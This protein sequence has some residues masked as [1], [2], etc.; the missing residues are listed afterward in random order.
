MFQANSEKIMGLLRPA[1]PVLDVGG[2][3]HPLNRPNYIMGCEPFEAADTIAGPSPE[4]IPTRRSA[5]RSSG[6]RQPP[7]SS[8]ITATDIRDW[9]EMI[10][11]GKAGYVEVPSR[12]WETCRGSAAGIAGLSHHRCLIEIDGNGV[13]FLSRRRIHNWRYLLPSSALRL[14]PPEERVQPPFWSARNLFGP[15]SLKSLVPGEH[16]L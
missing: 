7:G 10:R 1:D 9:A 8:G 3:A 4:T 5:V 16:G 11:S 13:R 12:I 6:S 14:L 2:W 15:T